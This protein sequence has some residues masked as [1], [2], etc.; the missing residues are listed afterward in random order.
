M[1]P[2]RSVKSFGQHDY[3]YDIKYDY[4]MNEHLIIL[5]NIVGDRITSFKIVIYFVSLAPSSFVICETYERFIHFHKIILTQKSQE[6]K[7]HIDRKDTTTILRYSFRMNKETIHNLTR[8][9]E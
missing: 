4:H 6:I 9:F 8:S 7:I 5:Q 2:T 1:S 3:Y